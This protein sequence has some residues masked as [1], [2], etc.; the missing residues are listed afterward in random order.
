MPTRKKRGKA[1]KT[2]RK[3]TAP[4]SAPA[5]IERAVSVDVVPIKLDETL[6]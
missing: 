3:R 6:F 4:K 5:A 1:A 2:I